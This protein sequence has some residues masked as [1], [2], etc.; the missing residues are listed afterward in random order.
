MDFTGGWD[1]GCK[2]KEGG[3]EDKEEVHKKK[4]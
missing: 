3:V 4:Y 1:A 2:E